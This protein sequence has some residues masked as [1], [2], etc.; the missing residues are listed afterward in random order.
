MIL[1]LGGVDRG[2]DVS[3][4]GLYALLAHPLQDNF[5]GIFNYDLFFKA[6]Y[7][8]FHLHFGLIGLRIIRLLSYFLGAFFLAVFLKNIT[9]AGKVRSLDFGISLLGLLAGY[10]FLPQTLSYNHLSV[11]LAC[12]WLA[13]ISGNLQKKRILITLGLVLALLAF[14]K[15]P[16]AGFL[17][18]GTIIFS[19]RAK[20]SIR[21]L[22]LLVLPFVL[23][24]FALLCFVD[25]SATQRLWSGLGLMMG[26]SDYA[27]GT[28]IKHT[29]VGVF[30]IGLSFLG[31]FLIFRFLTFR[32]LKLVGLLAWLAALSW[33][34]HI[35]EEWNHVVLLLTAQLLGIISVEIQAD[36]WKSPQRIWI[37][38][39]IAMPFVIHFGSNV[40][41]LRIGIHYWV[42]WI[43]AL[44]IS[45]RNIPGFHENQGGLVLGI[46]TCL[47]VFAGIWWKPFEQNSLWNY[48]VSW[49]YLP[50]KRI[51][52]MPDQVQKLKELKTKKEI[53]SNPQLLAVYRNSGIPFLL[54]KTMPKSPGFWDENQLKG[55]FPKALPELPLIYNPISDLPIP[56]VQDPILLSE[57]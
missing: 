55:F 13:L 33:L 20:V 42:F 26:R 53:Q 1:V 7:K 22:G 3:D 44:F 41:W 28:L 54:G 9:Q 35:T 14:V 6:F 8:L 4:E 18:L 21:Y 52:L 11:V 43:L 31:S 37:L 12:F 48:R 50:G 34:T 49:E 19:I 36:F 46:V 30:W 47:L 39:L 10:A 38:L 40:Y 24:E 5:A 29:W 23:M 45:M 32:G 2:F 25:A 51:K 56:P 16:T 15:I 17:F 27:L 57:F